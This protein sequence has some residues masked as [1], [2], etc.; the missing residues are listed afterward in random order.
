MLLGI[1]HRAE[2]NGRREV[3]GREGTA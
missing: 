2:D 1:K 3:R